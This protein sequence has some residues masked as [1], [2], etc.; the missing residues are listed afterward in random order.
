MSTLSNFISNRRLS[1]A[2]AD[3]KEL[4]NLKYLFYPEIEGLALVERRTGHAS[5]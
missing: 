1:Q 2:E 4:M 5:R 3:Q